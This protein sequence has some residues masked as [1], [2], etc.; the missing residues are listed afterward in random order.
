MPD[1]TGN[2]FH[3]GIRKYALINYF[4]TQ[5]WPDRHLNSS[6]IYSLWQ[7]LSKITSKN[8][9]NAYKLSP[10]ST[11]YSILQFT[12]LTVSSVMLP[13]EAGTSATTSNAQVPEEAGTSGTTSNA[14][15]PG[16]QVRIGKTI[17]IWSSS[18]NGEKAGGSVG[19]K[20]MK[21]N[22]I[23]STQIFALTRAGLFLI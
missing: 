11:S 19:V 7:Y 23:D 18:S 12:L 14:Q 9:N 3:S 16:I 10:A 8:I 15:V 6:I 2:Y 1:R 22:K 20:H 4:E 13:K 17:I 5:M 21:T